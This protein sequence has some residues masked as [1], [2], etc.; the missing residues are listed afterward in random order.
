MRTTL[1]PGRAGIAVQ[2]L[3]FSQQH[4]RGR[5]LVAFDIVAI[6]LASYVALAMRH[7]HLFAPGEL[8]PFVPMALAPLLVRPLI[9]VRFGLY[10]RVWSHASVEELVQV[11]AASAAGS[12][13]SVAVGIALWWPFSSVATFIGPSFWAIEFILVVGLV[14]GGRFLIRFASEWQRRRTVDTDGERRVPTLL[15][16]AGHAGAVIA[17]SAMH[18]PKAGVRPVGFLDDDPSAIGKSVAGVPVFGGIDALRRAITATSA[19]MLLITMPTA[20]GPTIRAVMEAALAEGLEVRT[21][22]P[23]HELMDGSI[24]AYRARRVKLDDLL[25]GRWRPTTRRPSKTSS[26]KRPWSSPERVAR[27]ARS[28]PARS[29]ACDLRGWCSSTG[30]RARSTRSSES[31]RSGISTVA[32][33]GRS[34]RTWSMS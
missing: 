2:V 33:R 34:R 15:F 32:V 28:W 16:G 19:E 13:L 4:L 27:S 10:R 22:P 20:S 14:G 18:E 8:A 30:P 6:A 24:D 1:V 17:R 11:L 31:W 21:V 9:S 25:G 29:T 3:G 5:H 7:E 23:I 26:G 12:L